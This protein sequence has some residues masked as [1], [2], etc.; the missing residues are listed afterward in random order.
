MKKY[1]L[2][3]IALLVGLAVGNWLPDIDQKTGLLV[4][5]SIVTHGPL[6]PLIVFAAALGSRSMRLRWFALGVTL[7]V[8]I[9]LSFDLF[10]KGWSGFAL[11]NVPSYGW[12]APWF[13]WT[14]IAVSTIA[15]I[16]LAF[17]LARSGL[18]NSVFL[19]SLI[20]AF[21]YIAAGEDAFWRPLFA[22]A[23]ATVISL[24]QAARRAIPSD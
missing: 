22:L 3:F 6:V 20:F 24:T 18:D 8:A 17:R 21:S 7:G 1:L 9:H 14:W 23:V 2:G 12:T 16:Y 4:H 15:C 5:R 19:L 11:I 10:P 13:S